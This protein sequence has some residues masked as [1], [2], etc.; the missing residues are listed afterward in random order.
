M[1]VLAQVIPYFLS[2]QIV[3]VKKLAFYTVY[4]LALILLQKLAELPFISH[5]N[6]F[7][8]CIIS[9]KNRLLKMQEAR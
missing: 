5:I 6:A 9:F 8:A 1:T 7:T 2:W 4:F 3:L